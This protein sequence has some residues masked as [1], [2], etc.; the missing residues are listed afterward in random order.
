MTSFPRRS[1]GFT[2]I[3]ICMVLVLLGILAAVAVPKFFDLQ[4]ESRQRAA[5]AA[6][7]EAQAR[8]NAVL[9]QKLLEGC[10]CSQAVA[11]VNADLASPDGRIA[12]G[13]GKLFG[14][15]QLVFAPLS[16][17]GGAVPVTAK[18]DGTPVADGAVLGTLVAAQC[19]GVIGNGPE[20]LSGLRDLGNT[21]GQILASYKQMNAVADPEKLQQAADLMS[22]ILAQFG[23]PLASDVKYWRIVNSGNQSNVFLL[24]EDIKD[25][26]TNRRVPFIQ[27]Q[28]TG[29]GP[30][31][32]FVGMIGTTPI[33][34][35]GAILVEDGNNAKIWNDETYSS[36][37]AYGGAENGGAYVVKDSNGSWTFFKQQ[38]AGFSSYAEAYEAFL[39]VDALYRRPNAS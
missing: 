20:S 28:Q 23:E 3:E 33:S 32:Y 38:T 15:Y 27:A 4:D 24:T 19:A 25:S 34:G 29:D 35:K 11:W 21:R 31:T 5:A 9:G 16:A 14:D 12:D 17:A 1:A 6:I 36:M 22:G 7:A 2:L 18:Y 13:D 26:T 30:I 37:A 39:H 8:I 10:G